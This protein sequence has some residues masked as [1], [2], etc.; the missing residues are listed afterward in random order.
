[1]IVLQRCRSAVAKGAVI[2]IVVDRVALSCR[3]GRLLNSSRVALLA[4]SCLPLLHFLV[5]SDGIDG[6]MQSGRAI[7]AVQVVAQ[8]SRGGQNRYGI[9]CC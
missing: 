4:N 1:V 5:C 6:G 2:L 8:A 9:L 7:S 3:Q